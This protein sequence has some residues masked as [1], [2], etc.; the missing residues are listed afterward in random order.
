M[1]RSAESVGSKWN[2]EALYRKRKTTVLAG[3]KLLEN[4]RK[5]NVAF[6]KIAKVAISDCERIGQAP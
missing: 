1:A 3:R 2:A 6:E 5:A 4:L